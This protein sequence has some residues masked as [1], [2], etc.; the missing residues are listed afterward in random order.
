MADSRLAPVLRFL[1]RRVAPPAAEA[2]DDASL[3]LRFVSGGD[4]DAFDALVRRHGGLVW[5]V[6]LRV[7]GRAE[8][9]EDA[10]QAT[11]L[12]FARRAASVRK[13]AALPSWLHGVACRVART[14]RGRRKDSPGMGT[15]H[16]PAPECD[17][18]TQAAARE[19]GRLVEEELGR[20]PER[21]RLPVLLCYWEGLTNEE[22]AQRLGWP[23]G[24][25]KTRLAKAR[26]VLHDRLSSRGV[27]LPAGVIALLLAPS[28]GPEAAAGMAARG[29]REVSREAA[30][31]AQRV[32][33][34]SALLGLKSAVVLLLALSAAAAGVG[35]LWQAPPEPMSPAG[36]NKANAGPRLALQDAVR[37]DAYGDPL[38]A[39]AVARLGTVRF[40][41]RGFA[42][43]ALAYSPDGKVLAAA[44]GDRGGVFLW[45]AA[46]GKPIH[47]LGPVPREAYGV[48]FSPDGR[49]VAAGD[50]FRSVRVWDVASGK[51]VRQI[52]VRDPLLVLA[53]AFSPDGK[54]IAAAQSDRV[55][56]FDAATGKERWRRG[57]SEEAPHAIAFS[58]DGKLVA[59]AGRDKNVRLWDAATGTPR[60]VLTAPAENNT[61]GLRIAFAPDG[62]TLAAGGDD[63][64]VRLWDPASGK[65]VGVV[66]K[67]SSSIMSIAFSRDGRILATGHEDG[68]IRLWDPVGR[69]QLREIH[70]HASFVGAL[71]FS[72]GGDTLASGTE[73]GGVVRL[74]DPRT[75][76]ERGDFAGPRGWVSWL[77][78]AADGRSLYVGSFDQTVRR[79]EWAGGK[80]ETL[81]SWHV[82]GFRACAE[83]LTPSGPVAAWCDW[84]DNTT[85]VRDGGTKG[86]P[87]VLKLSA[88][89]V[90]KLALS[91]DGRRLVVG[92][93]DRTIRVWNTRADREVCKVEG[94]AAVD[95]VQ[96][97]FGLAF[98]PDGRS[99]VSSAYP[100]LARDPG[101]GGGLCL[102][103]AANGKERRTFHC[104]GRVYRT[105]FSPDG[106]RLAGVIRLQRHLE[107]R[108]WDVATG[109]EVVLPSVVKN[110]WA[111]SFSPDGKLLAVGDDRVLSV[112]NED[113]QYP[114]V[115]IEV[116]SG[117]EV[118]RFRAH[119]AGVREAAFS[120]DGRLLATGGADANVVLWDLSGHATPGTPIAADPEKCWADLASPDASRAYAAVWDLAAPPGR[121][122]GLLRGHLRPVSPLDAAGQRRLRR[123]LADLDGDDFPTRQRA[124]RELEALGELAE[125]ALRA[126]LEAGPTPEVRRQI[127]GL[128]EAL[129]AWTPARLRVSRAVAALEMAGTADARRLLAELAGGA[130]EVLQT[131]EA[132][133]A[134]ARLAKR[135]AGP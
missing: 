64:Q 26:A 87:R 27:V 127:E 123:W 35:A 28:G 22:A 39:G 73:I 76:R 70:A 107:P 10:F 90:W 104:P 80:E 99:F 3:L 132:Q 122:V 48:A 129:S 18:A 20:L 120:P 93:A 117:Q 116:A 2:A 23:A 88:R 17:P 69:H 125:P 106:R 34:G 119:M 94:L 124:A 62:K 79:W 63:R 126:A 44:G 100:G 86:G 38:P 110:C 15:E 45:D 71:A 59:T 84:K 95:S 51:E 72:P 83:A 68:L 65:E 113:R 67:S 97:Y 19:M 21:L 5:R 42:T 111:V 96:D 118:R 50:G 1:H 78:F 89:G 12:V 66:G 49:R 101:Q 43:S 105:C 121:A 58:P 91:P 4:R 52:P 40:R 81:F 112:D 9:A 85:R 57:G 133:A 108:V 92:S 130:P 75:G 109:K 54:S 11:W 36:E 24:T 37:T 55:T 14:A 102:F 134:L 131:R 128:L 114:V 6:C 82:P 61:H 53:V 46:S 98:A 31:L 25:V 13:P 29:A 16:L 115:V 30:A 33:P 32:L 60:A 135:P 77:A 7:A 56:L 47:E 103:D 8:L 74:W 41:H